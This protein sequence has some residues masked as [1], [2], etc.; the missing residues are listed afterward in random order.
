MRKVA[1]D[2]V[3]LARQKKSELPGDLGFILLMMHVGAGGGLAYCGTVER[4]DGV[5]AM[6]EH[7]RHMLSR[8]VAGLSYQHGLYRLADQLYRQ[9]RVP[10]DS[11][12]VGP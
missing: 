2:F 3:A 9:S 1:A 5:R 7:L 10:G 6:I 8:P 12:Y 11:D 4:A